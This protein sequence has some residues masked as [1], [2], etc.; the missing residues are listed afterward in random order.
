MI[1]NFYATL[2]QVV[3]AKSIEFVLPEGSTVR[4]LLEEMLRCYPALRSELLDEHGQMHP[5]VH[6]FVGGRDSAFLEKG[7]DTVLDPQAE[8]GLFPAVGGG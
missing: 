7:M 1:V 2:R 8:V 5:Y 4:D 3:G 6:L